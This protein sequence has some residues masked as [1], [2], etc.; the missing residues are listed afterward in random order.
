MFYVIADSGQFDG[1]E[2]TVENGRKIT[3]I[4][5]RLR[6]AAAEQLPVVHPEN[7]EFKNVT[8]SQISGS[9]THSE[10]HLKN[11]VTVATGSLD[12]KK[13]ETWTGTLDRCPCGTGTCAKMAAL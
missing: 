5:S 7:P 13:S 1:L 2:L 10:A 8:I 6:V 12:W 9:P 3:S 4:A 11:A